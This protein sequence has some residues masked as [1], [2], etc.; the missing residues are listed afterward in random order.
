MK[1]TY[2]TPNTV[3]IWV[4]TFA[5]ESEFDAAC[6]T[7]IV[8]ALRLPTE[9]ASVCEVAFEPGCVSIAA[10]LEGF[11]GWRSFSPA[12][13]S[14]AASRSIPSANAAL[15]CYYV[16]CTDAPDAWRS[17]HFLGSFPGCDNN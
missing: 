16:G 5:T 11:S 2:P 13:V 3:S 12:A 7:A 14:V 17:L 10:L 15:V 1:V 4:G 9:L 6:R 8:P